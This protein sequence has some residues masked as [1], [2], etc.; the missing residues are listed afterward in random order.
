MRLTWDESKRKKTLE[1]RGLDF[2]RC[3][4]V[5]EGPDPTFDY[6][7]TRRIYDERRWITVGFLDDKLVV[8]VHTERAESTRI[9]SMRL[10]EKEERRA[11]EKAMG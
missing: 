6:E 8:I 2:A 9:I 11:Y 7:D 3:A 10:A 4:E 1:E 5:F